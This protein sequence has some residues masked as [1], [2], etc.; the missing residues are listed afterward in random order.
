[1]D[2]KETHIHESILGGYIF[3]ISIL[4]SFNNKKIGSWKRSLLERPYMFLFGRP[5]TTF[6]LC[7]VAFLALFC[8]K[9]S[10]LSSCF[11]GEVFQPPS[12]YWGCFFLELDNGSTSF[13]TAGFGCDTQ[14][15]HLPRKPNKALSA[16]ACGRR[17][18]QRLRGSNQ[19][20]NWNNKNRAA[21]NG[22]TQKKTW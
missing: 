5:P 16:A 3:G 7:K 2:L 12:N 11:R 17:E 18:S 10:F 4:D 9:T 22:P 13:P 20:M 8:W 1:M 21:R 19:A 6:V 15:I 14:W